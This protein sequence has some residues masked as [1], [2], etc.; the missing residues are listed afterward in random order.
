MTCDIGAGA[1]APSLHSV[2]R[3]MCVLRA[4]RGERATLSNAELVRR[5]GLPKATVNRFTN[6]LVQLGWLRPSAAG[7][8]FELGAAAVGIGHAYLAHSALLDIAQ[9]VLQDLADGLE[10]CVAL[11]LRD[12]LD[13]LYIGCSAGGNVKTLRM[14]LGS[15]VPVGTTSIGH[16]W[17]WGLQSPERD[18]LIGRLTLQ[19]GADAASMKQSIDAS[20]AEL[21]A[22]GA[23]LSAGAYQRDV[24]GVALPLRIGPS[25]RLLG[26][27]CGKAD[28]HADLAAERLRIVPALRKTAARLEELL[29][30]FDREF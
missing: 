7:R 5:T 13:I 6:T 25:R 12:G 30:D 16:A 27:S 10:V 15:V 2:E 22:T 29:K 11:G 20:F 23:C 26:L 3:G 21:A 24:W 17:L 14:G 28:A 18:A 19:A 9:P 1:P 4:F 8:G